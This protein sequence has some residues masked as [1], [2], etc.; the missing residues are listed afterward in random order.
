MMAANAF[1]C[2]N[3]G[4]F[5]ASTD[6]FTGTG[7]V[8]EVSSAAKFDGGAVGLFAVDAPWG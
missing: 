4:F 3:R 6:I 8:G 7:V 5:Q 2:V 1:S